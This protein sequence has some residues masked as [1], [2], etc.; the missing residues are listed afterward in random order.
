MFYLSNLHQRDCCQRL[1]SESFEAEKDQAVNK[2]ADVTKAPLITSSKAHSELWN[3][4]CKWNVGQLK[5]E[6]DTKWDFVTLETCAINRESFPM[7]R[8]K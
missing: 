4:T 3:D 1:L 5:Y 7:I 6:C 8:E 2:M